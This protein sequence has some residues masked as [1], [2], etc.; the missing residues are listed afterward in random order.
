M[1]VLD[2]HVWLWW[3]NNPEDL[4]PAARSRIEQ[5][6]K[7]RSVHVSTI[8][9]WE[10]AMLVAK[11]WLRLSMD[12]NDWVVK[13]EALPFL[14]FVPVT[15]QIALKSVSLPGDIHPDPADRI[16]IATAMVHGG[17]LI[18]RDEKILNYPHVETLW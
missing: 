5:S 14:H 13:T 18:T 9:T 8:S 3:L 1:I 17:T 7:S 2:T 10:V 12:V 16:I 11:G 6:M 15:N 4:S